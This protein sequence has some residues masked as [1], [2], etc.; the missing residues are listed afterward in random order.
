MAATF[1]MDQLFQF[2]ITLTSNQIKNA[3]NSEE[4]EKILSSFTTRFSELFGKL[5][6]K[7]NETII[8][9]GI[10]PLFVIALEESLP[11]TEK[12][13]KQL[14]EHVLT[15]YK[16]MLEDFVLEPQRRFMSSSKNP[17]STFVENT[18]KSNQKTY[19]NEFFKLQEISATEEEFAFDINRCLYH[20]IFKEFGREDLGSIMCEYDGIIAKNVAKWVRFEREETIA[21]GFPRCT[22]RFF[23]VKQKFSVNPIIDNIYSL[24]K[25]IDDSTEMLSKQELIEKGFEGET[26][27]EDIVKL[28]ETIKNHPGIKTAK[29]EE[30]LLF[31]S[32]SSYRRHEEWK[33]LFNR[34]VPLEERSKIIRNLPLKLKEEKINQLITEILENPYELASLKWLC[35]NYL[36]HHISSKVG[37]EIEGAEEF[38]LTYQVEEFAKKSPEISFEVH[39]HNSRA[40]IHVSGQGIPE[41]K[42]KESAQL[43][44]RKIFDEFPDASLSAIKSVLSTNHITTKYFNILE[45]STQPF[46]LRELALRILISRVGFNL[47]PFLKTIA[48]NKMDDPFLRGRALDSLSW[49]SSNLHQS[50]NTLEAIK[51]SPIPVQRSIVDFLARHGINEEIL[52]AIAKDEN[53]SIIIRAIALRN[54]GTFPNSEVT[55][56]L[57]NSVIERSSNELLRQASLE[58]LAKHET[59]S[60]TRPVFKIFIDPEESSFIR[61]EALETLKDLNFIPPEDSM[62]LGRPDWITTLGLKQLMED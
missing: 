54:L 47:V 33:L 36:Q 59:S 13:K 22:F 12:D 24:L 16:V 2:I 60:I 45:D 30:E 29:N 39:P 32:V 4:S 37:F 1:D 8:F 50:F 48:E 40:S 51:E 21:E 27:L 26:E 7:Q 10:N 9:H 42:L 44:R 43:L 17:W 18:R 58:A 53:L 25:I 14:T 41:N 62:Q 11:S 19:D 35:L 5:K 31:G 15:I 57:L 34:K 3:F 46:Q 49:F 55:D 56:F 61:M 38:H 23:R 6:E 28:I 20:E 52:I